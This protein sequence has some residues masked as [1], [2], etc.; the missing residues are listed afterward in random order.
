MKKYFML[1]VAM[2]LCILSAKAQ[3]NNYYMTITMNNGSTI[4]IGPN[5]IK[6]IT[7]NNGEITV[8]GERIG[9]FLTQT[10]ADNQYVLKEELSQLKESIDKLGTSQVRINPTT[11]IWEISSDGGQTYISTGVSAVG[12]DGKDGRDGD[13]FFESVV[14]VEDNGGQYA[15]FTVRNGVRFRVPIQ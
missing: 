3:G 4:S 7:F 12:R 5:D 9:T 6:N 14:I 1:F 15:L 11:S 10:M 2:L 13:S 8:S